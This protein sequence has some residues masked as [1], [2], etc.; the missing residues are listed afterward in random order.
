MPGQPINIVLLVRLATCVT[1]Q[2][3]RGGSIFYLYV[4]SS[5]EA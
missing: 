1:L 3:M 5:Q 4:K 2:C